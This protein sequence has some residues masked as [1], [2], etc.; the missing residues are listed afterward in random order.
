MKKIIIFLILAMVFAVSCSSSKKS[1][2]DADILPDE[3]GIND[4]DA[5]LDDE[6]NVDEDKTDDE[7]PDEDADYD[8]DN[9]CNPNPCE[10]LERTTGECIASYDSE[11]DYSYYS[12]VCE[13][14]YKYYWDYFEAKCTN[15]CEGN[16]C[17]NKEHSN[18]HCSLF[19][20]PA[21]Y[22]CGCVEGY[23]WEYFDCVKDKNTCDN[24]ENPCAGMANSTERC[25]STINNS[26]SCECI[27][28][29]FWNGEQCINPCSGVSCNQFEH[30]TG[31][32]RTDNAFTFRCDCDEGY[33]W[34][35]GNKGCLNKKPDAVNVCTG[36][37]KCYNNKKEIPCPAEGEDFFGQDAQY[38]RLGYCMPQN[39][40]IDYSV[41]NE[42]VVVD[43]NTGMM[44]QQK[45]PPI[46]E[47]YIEEVNGYCNNLVYGGYDDWRLP[48][49]TDFV[50]ITDFGR[51]D[52]A[53][54]TEYFPDYGS[55]WT[56]NKRVDRWSGGDLPHIYYYTYY[57]SSIF[58]FK[59]PLTFQTTT[60]SYYEEN[61][62]LYQDYHNYPHSYNIRCVRGSDTESTT[63]TSQTFGKNLMWN[64]NN[65]TILVKKTGAKHT[66]QEAL[67]YCSEL[68]YAG[69][70]DWRLPNIRE[71]Y[72][73]GNTGVHSSTTK[74]ASLDSDYS[75]IS[76]ETTLK[77]TTKNNTLCIANDSCEDGKF[78]NGEKCAKNPCAGNPCKS[79]S[80]SNG[81]CTVLDEENYSCNC[82]KNYKWSPEKLQCVRTC[83]DN[84]CNSYSNSDKQCYDDDVEGFYCGCNEPYFWNAN[85]RKCTQNC[86][87]NPC[88]DEANSTHECF[89]DEKNGYTCGCNDGY[90]WLRLDGC[91]TDFCKLDSCKNI[92][93]SSGECRIVEEFGYLCEC[94]NG[95]LWNPIEKNCG[96]EGFS[97]DWGTE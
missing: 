33:Y 57:Y 86:D 19:D 1:E 20:T 15:A 82:N 26:Y 68:D 75:E 34:W 97:F 73:T 59:E 54:K 91:V 3:D 21:A 16:P 28:E 69:I 96:D 71:L 27:E 36:Q 63:F 90:V 24:P 30:G 80:N 89:P 44:W 61:T 79:D 47:L 32:C 17:A 49:V 14:R 29:Y 70:S 81:T 6:V 87:H 45:I 94:L 51:Y 56:S 5:D 85:S 76:K 83:Q 78:W 66:W 22:E 11:Y 95:T 37:N 40:S 43:N 93:N 46:E 60:L 92:P 9:P 35:G 62:L 52:P 65:D 2:N 31:E 50:T 13:D 25:I 74:M 38:A 84:P 58:D 48:S 67:E 18:G 41:E 8:E 72:L 77:E 12:C 7:E 10:G 42:P 39:Y 23:H 53:I 55:F 4:E 64:Y 88:L